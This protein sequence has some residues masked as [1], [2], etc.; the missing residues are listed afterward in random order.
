MLV[1]ILIGTPTWVWALLTLLVGLGLA[2]RRPRTVTL[3][4]VVLL[5]LAMTGLSMVGTYSAFHTSPWSWILWAGAAL[6]AITWFASA[7]APA[8][9]R[10]DSAQKRFHLRGSCEPLLLMMAIFCTRYGVAVA[11]AMHPAW[12]QDVAVAAIVASICGALSGVFVGR[13]LRM[14]LLTR[15]PAAPGPPASGMAWG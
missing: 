7:D 5:P 3:R 4:R 14:I 12:A 2:Q 15:E 10:Y 11:I 9:I 6:A 1:Q 8:G 13:M